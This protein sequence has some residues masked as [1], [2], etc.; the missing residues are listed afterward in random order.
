MSAEAAEEDNVHLI[1]NNVNE[2]NSLEQQEEAQIAQQN[3]IQLEAEPVQLVPTTNI[4]FVTHRDPISILR[5]AASQIREHQYLDEYTFAAKRVPFWKQGPGWQ[6]W[7]LAFQTLFL[8]GKLE[9]SFLLGFLWTWMWDYW[10]VFLPTWVAITVYTGS[11]VMWIIKDFYKWRK[12]QKR[13]QRRIRRHESR[14][15]QL[16]ATGQASNTNTLPVDAT[17]RSPRSERRMLRKRVDRFYAYSILYGIISLIAT[18]FMLTLKLD[19]VTNISALAVSL[20]LLVAGFVHTFLTIILLGFAWRQS[21]QN[22]G[23]YAIKNRSQTVFVTSTVYLLLCTT[24]V[25]L[26]LKI[27][28]QI[29]DFKLGYS[30]CFSPLF[31]L[32]AITWLS[33]IA[34]FGFSFY[35][36]R[37]FM[38]MFKVHRDRIDDEEEANINVLLERRLR[39]MSLEEKKVL[40][41]YR[42]DVAIFLL[43][44]IPVS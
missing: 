5:H 41:M 4:R 25:L 38:D 19:K 13:H 21:P 14:L 37:Q 6:M 3:A 1:T 32:N 36:Q 23:H 29:L 35:D 30:A 22:G 28:Y 39:P 40:T 2:N 11:L 10:I 24:A 12:S 27:D 44:Q 26:A 8:F 17:L 33:A 7:V 18:L 15:E 16:R 34:S 42:L 43:V 31:V 9:S 20:P